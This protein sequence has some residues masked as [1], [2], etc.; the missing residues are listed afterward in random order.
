MSS[1]RPLRT[2]WPRRA[3]RTLA[4]EGERYYG[5]W[6]QES[7]EHRVGSPLSPAGLS[8]TRLRLAPL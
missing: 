6:N 3:E 5:E 1:R 7:G 4:S 2:R 8:T